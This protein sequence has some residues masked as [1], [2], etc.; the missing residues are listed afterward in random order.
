MGFLAALGECWVALR[1]SLDTSCV[2]NLLN[3]DEQI[4]DE[5]VELLKLGMLGDVQ[6]A[7]TDALPKEVASDGPGRRAEIARRAKFLPVITLPPGRV[8][9]RDDLSRLLFSRLWP[10]SPGTS[11]MAEHARRDCDHLASHMLSGATAFVTRDVRLREKATARADQPGLLVVPPSMAVQLAEQ[12][13]P[14]PAEFVT[15]SF[16]VRRATA[17]DRLAIAEL[18]APVRNDYPEF[19][20]WLDRTLSDPTAVLNLGVVDQAKVHGVAFWK[21]KDHRTAKLTTFYLHP[22]ARN[23]GLGQHML[24]HCLRQW[25]EKGVERAFLTAGSEKEDIIRFCLA[26]GFRIEGVAH[27]RYVA[28]GN[29]VVLAKHLFHRRVTDSDL[30]S[31]LDEVASTVFSVASPSAVFGPRSWFLPPGATRVRLSW[32]APRRHATLVRGESNQVGQTESVSVADMEEL[33]YPVRFALR[34]RSAYMIPIQPQ[35]A[36]RMMDIPRRQESLFRLNDKLMLR[37][38]NAYYCAPVYAE[39]DVKG[40]P[41]L[42]YVSAPESAVTGVARIIERVVAPPEDLFLRFGQIGVYGVK[43]IRRHVAGRGPHEGMAMAMHFGWWVP[44]Q[45]PVPLARAKA[46][47]GLNGHPQRMQRV[48]Y[49]IFEALAKEGGVKW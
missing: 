23:V 30:Q 16:V 31:F 44:F 9:E 20:G 12:A 22:E 5:L 4:D 35:W 49:D 48:G 8:A 1:F 14:K 11:N 26:F 15:R 36:E 6:L 41:I 24:F 43:D 2:L 27:R 25:V 18:L 3:P 47:G 46:I 32:D 10:N 33:F 28:G 39:H 7:V 42:F 34:D 38:D 17:Q 21:P 40:A 13:R 19:D 29:E 45:K 37:I